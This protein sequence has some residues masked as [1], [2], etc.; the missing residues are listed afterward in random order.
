MIID[1]EGLDG[2]FK[3]TTHQ[4]IK[5]VWEKEPNLYDG[6]TPIFQQF[7][8]YDE[9]SSWFVRSYLK[10]DLFDRAMCLGPSVVHPFY[11]LD[12]FAF[13]HEKNAEESPPTRYLWYKKQ[14]KANT[15]YIFDRYTYSSLMYQTAEELIKRGFNVFDT[16]TD[17]WM[18]QTDSLMFDMYKVESPIIP[19]ADWVIYFYMPLSALDRINQSRTNAGPQDMND[20]NIVLRRTI[21]WIA[22]RVIFGQSEDDHNKEHGLGSNCSA[23]VEDIKFTVKFDSRIIPFCVWNFIEDRPKNRM[24]IVSEIFQ[25][26]GIIIP[27]EKR[28]EDIEKKRDEINKA[29]DCSTKIGSDDPSDS[30]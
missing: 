2:C 10:Q 6:V 19:P 13:W 17:R 21:N 7:P 1:F 20:N 18:E 29:H 14:S 9:A 26:L 5:T 30:E 23:A 22:R 25:I 4:L 15:L 16:P 12:R 24:E 27:F 3:T 8:R 28:C 11:Y